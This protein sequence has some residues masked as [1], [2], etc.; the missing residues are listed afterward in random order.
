MTNFL[1]A[2]VI[3]VGDVDTDFYN[4]NNWSDPTVDFSNLQSTTLVIGSGSTNNPIQKG[5]SANDIN[6]R[7]ES[8]DLIT[9]ANLIINGTLLPWNSVSLNGSLTL[10][11]PAYLNIRNLVYLG[12][13]ETGS[14]NLI[15]GS[16]HS[17]NQF[18]IGYGNGGA[19]IANILGGTLYAESSLE[20]ASNP[21]GTNP[22]GIVTIDGGT[23]DVATAVNIG[24]NG[25]IYIEGVGD[26]VVTGDHTTALNNYISNGKITSPINTVLEVVYDG[27]RTTVRIP[28]DPNRL[29]KEYASYI[30]LD[31]GILQATIEKATSNITS[32]KVNGVE[33]LQQNGGSRSGTYYDF[34]GSYG[35]DKISGTTFSIK[36][37]TADYIDVSFKRTYSPGV[38]LA[39]CDADIHYVLKKDDKGLY[40]YSILNHKAEYPDFDLGSW[41]QV[42]WIG[43][44]GTD[45]LTEKIYVNDVKKWQM[46]SV[47][48]NQN[49]VATPIQEII[50]LTTGVRAGKYD[51]KYEYSE[52]LLELPVWG[53]ASDVNKIGSWYR[54]WKS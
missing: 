46:P 42:I 2:Q 49:A 29:I 23:V 14:L 16:M 5:G 30:I 41:R 40:T 13:N 18:Y 21:S 24:A 6:K 31:N 32:L 38:Y 22:T 45:Y 4:Q 54:V 8:L 34:T 19:G 39:P 51:G 10:N 52:S 1:N 12:K 9:G 27:S 44:N 11:A 43:D 20:I 28:Q 48:D 26:L 37:E 3:W 36:E 47:Y 25:N 33:T 53:H 15:G 35:F 17:K 50:K 7:P